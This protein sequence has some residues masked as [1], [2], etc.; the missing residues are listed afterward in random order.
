MIE[1]QCSPYKEGREKRW[2]TANA[3]INETDGAI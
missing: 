3:A 2:R 1:P